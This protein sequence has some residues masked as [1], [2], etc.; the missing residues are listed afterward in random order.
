MEAVKEYGPIDDE[1]PLLFVTCYNPGINI[2][3][4]Q[5][6]QTKTLLDKY[7]LNKHDFVCITNEKI[8]GIKCIPINALN[9]TSADFQMEMWRCDYFD[10]PNTSVMY[11]DLDIVPLD[12]F[13]IP[14]CP[15]NSIWMI[16]IFSC[17]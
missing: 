3:T 8:D 5:V 4:K 7:C 2:S 6:K 15:K 14:R 11:I 16:A 1:H 17:N 12:Y 10:N 13:R 9:I